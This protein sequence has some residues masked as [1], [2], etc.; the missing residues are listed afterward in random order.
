MALP[1]ILPPRRD[2]EQPAY[3]AKRGHKVEIIVPTFLSEEMSE[4]VSRQA[5]AEVLERIDPA[6]R[7]DPTIFSSPMSMAARRCQE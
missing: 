5:A 6:R 7:R 2:H 4:E 1:V 3:H